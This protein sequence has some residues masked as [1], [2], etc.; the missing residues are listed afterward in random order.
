[1]PKIIKN[2]KRTFTVSGRDV[3]VEVESKWENNSYGRDRDGNRGK[4]I[5]ELLSYT[6]DPPKEFDDGA[7]FGF[8]DGEDLEYHVFKLLT[9]S[10]PEDL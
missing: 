1:M 5:A 4:T 3:T 7:R 9:K 10:N 8:D 6:F 2:F